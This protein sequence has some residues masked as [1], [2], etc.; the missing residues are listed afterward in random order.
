MDDVKEEEREKRTL[1]LLVL[2]KNDFE[3]KILPKIC[4]ELIAL[5]EYESCQNVLIQYNGH[6]PVLDTM[7]SQS[8]D[9][10]T[11]QTCCDALYC[12]MNSND[13]LR[14]LIQKSPASG[15]VIEALEKFPEAA[16]LQAVGLRAI[17]LLATSKTVCNRLIRD[18]EILSVVLDAMKSFLMDAMVQAAGCMALHYLLAA[19]VEDQKQFFAEEK[20]FVIMD[21]IENH[22]DKPCV[23]QEAFWAL[24]TVAFP[25]ETYDVLLSTS[26]KHLF[27]AMA[28][29]PENLG[30][31]MAG[32]TVIETFARSDESTNFLEVNGASRLILAAIRNFPN[33]SDLQA[34]AFNLLDLLGT[35]IDNNSKVSGSNSETDWIEEAHTALTAHRNQPQVLDAVC[36]SIVRLLIDRPECIAKTVDEDLNLSLDSPILACLMLYMENA[37]VA[38]SACTALYQIMTCSEHF[39]KS[40]ME[41]GVGFEI[42]RTMQMYGQN[43]FVLSAACQALLGLCN[44]NEK[45]K[46]H[47]I[48]SVQT[49]HEVFAAV[50]QHW[51]EPT[52]VTAA[53]QLVTCLAENDVFRNQCLT[54]GVHEVIL[55]SMVGSKMDASTQS[56]ML[57]ALAVLSTAEGMVNILS[58]SDA[59]SLTVEVMNCHPNNIDIIMKGCI[60]LQALLSEV[61]EL[62]G[63]EEAATVIIKAME[64]FADVDNTS[65]EGSR[66]CIEKLAVIKS[67]QE[68]GCV[69]LLLLAGMSMDVAK[70]LVDLQIHDRLFHILEKYGDDEQIVNLACECLAI[71]SCFKDQILSSACIEGRLQA[72]ELLVQLGA[73]VNAGGGSD[74]PI[75]NAIKNHNV[76]LVEFLLKQGVNDLHD[77][78]KVSLSEN[79][80]ITGLLLMY[81]GLDIEAGIV[82]WSGLQLNDVHPKW[83]YATFYSASELVEG[84]GTTTEVDGSSA[85]VQRIITRKEKR[86]QRQARKS[87]L[88]GIDGK[89]RSKVRPRGLIGSTLSALNSTNCSD[90]NSRRSS[91][92]FSSGEDSVLQDDLWSPQSNY[93]GGRM[94]RASTTD[95]L[96]NPT[97]VRSRMR[98]PSIDE[99][100]LRPSLSVSAICD[101]SFLSIYHTSKSSIRCLPVNPHDPRLFENYASGT[102]PD[103]LHTL[104]ST[105]GASRI[106]TPSKGDTSS[107]TPSPPI[108]RNRQRTLSIQ[109]KRSLFANSNQ[110]PLSHMHE[111]SMDGTNQAIPDIILESCG[112]IPTTST[113]LPSEVKKRRSHSA[114]TSATEKHEVIQCRIHF[115]DLSSNR[116]P[117][118]EPLLQ[119]D[120]HLLRCFICLQKLD[121][122]NNLLSVFPSKLSP[123]LSNLKHLDLRNNKLKDF[124]THMFT[125]SSKLESLDV[126]HNKI[127]DVSKQPGDSCFSLHELNLS[128][129]NIQVFPKWLRNYV[130]ALQILNISCNNLEKLE[131]I[132]LQLLHLRTL[133]LCD[134]ALV[135]IPHKFLLNMSKLETL[136]ASNNQLS[137]LPDDLGSH[138]TQLTT[139]KL[140][141]NN[142]A[143]NEHPYIPRFL[144]KLPWVKSIDL[145]GNRL[146]VLPD[147]SYWKSQ[148]LRELLFADNSIRKLDLG[149]SIRSWRM[150]ERLSLRNNK[151]S[152]IPKE[153]GQLTSL[154]TLD[155]SQN[156]EL[157]TLPD[158]LGRLNRLWELPLDGLRL[159]LPPAILKGRTKDIVTFLHQR[160]KRAVPY[161]RM[162]LM[163]V[164]Y[165]GRGKTTLIRRLQREKVSKN[166]ATV[167]VNVKEW[168]ISVKHDRKP[169]DFL[170]STW[171]FAGQ[172][173]FYS[174]HPCFLTGRALYLV[175]FDLSKGINE[176]NTIRP[177]LLTIQ[178]LAPSCPVI[179]VGTHKDKVPKDQQDVILSGISEQIQQL[180][181]VRGFPKIQEYVEVSNTSENESIDHLR[182]VIARVIERMKIRGKPIIGQMIPYSYLTLQ[183]LI[184][185]RAQVLRDAKKPP[186]L[187]SHQIH[188]MI[189]DENVLLD[190]NILSQRLC[191]FYMRLE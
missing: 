128:N 31:Q 189:K 68:E 183:K 3:I 172:E 158:E 87:V 67:L 120:I 186:V 115:L 51:S 32:C 36:R 117:S 178:A 45:H 121:L 174:T 132:P 7:S 8:N 11:Q 59:Y 30:V 55:E 156:R 83:F 190:E 43:P 151:L 125:S 167:G 38:E 62:S 134:N 184:S 65:Q 22:V 149:D 171:D 107:S 69:V 46:E 99:S 28:R 97:P 163:L 175:V 123:Y 25:D 76:P 142:L 23:L 50:R 14:E 77:C 101:N 135:D 94:R 93:S 141:K 54:E 131:N 34:V 48:Q 33:D 109:D 119:A 58:Q 88:T 127:S 84:A 139:V 126:S 57:E 166:I 16:S 9:K 130:P 112:E 160:L 1:D 154:T 78:L 188:Q 81:I 191:G 19:D 95:C 75:L 124:P 73:D 13:K 80:E 162:K 79:D 37:D 52:L 6:H 129:N 85:I 21:A 98:K 91:F 159:D 147:P 179:L 74:P 47:L 165:G 96:Y 177:W 49:L 104:S 140:S 12:M 20:Y 42:T 137:S 29:F 100:V 103:I 44:S 71:L 24:N 122:S 66:Q 70:I 169:V 138:M 60:L 89:S 161:N 2:L 173:D 111:D 10:Q 41:K 157:S 145:S 39:Q 5:T 18:E 26:H 150:L 106:S 35:A 180:C 152:Q 144:L 187:L 185:R 181:S 72:V 148:S 92:G 64:H 153:L 143:I 53:I 61:K 40:L 56:V 133:K 155:L 168:K 136:H 15:Q 27:S 118:L 102:S 164:G 146:T 105:S 90:V 113:P 86:E 82:S 116:I 110:E 176:I 4:E 17:S 170:L 63:I 108:P 182:K 114:C